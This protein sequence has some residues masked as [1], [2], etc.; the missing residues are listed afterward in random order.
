MINSNSIYDLIII[1]SGAA[2]LFAAANV[3][4]GWKTLVLEKTDSPGQKLLLT[5]S[6]QCNLTNSEPIKE[7]LNRYGENGKHLRPVLFPFSNLALM[8]YFK[9]N[10]LPLKIRED[11][12]V[13]P[14]SMKSIDV[15]NLLLALCNKRSVTIQYKTAVADIIQSNKADDPGY[16]IKTADTQFF[17]KNVLIATGGESYPQTGSD[18][19]F[20]LCLEKLGLNLTPRRPALAPV[21]VSEYPFSN[22]SGLSFQSTVLTATQQNEQHTYK[23]EGS[24][25]LT[26]KCFSGPSVLEMSRYVTPGDRLNINY[27]PKRTPEDLRMAL[28]KTAAG[29]T[30]QI[31]TILESITALPRSFLEHCCH[32]CNIKNNEKAARLSGKDMETLAKRL[33]EDSF[34]I[35]GTGGFFEAMTTAGGVRL[36]DINLR[37]MEAKRFP[38][39]YFAGEVLD[40]DGDTGGYNLQFAFSSAKRCIE[41]MQA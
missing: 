3:P 12:K 30:K 4:A 31:V 5:G 24:L 27:L 29:S 10:G 21:F 26:H 25:L 16:T 11:G 2:G 32:R 36:D 15:L 8:E 6:R 9:Q 22:L 13:F 18:G 33:T 20:F 34:E 14:A 35:S 23:T 38:G 40:I 37:T 19:S 7:F 28:I 17:S 41:A 1:G 39:L